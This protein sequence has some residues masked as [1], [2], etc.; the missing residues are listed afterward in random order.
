[1]ASRA[2][3][4]KCRHLPSYLF[5]HL[6]PGAKVPKDLMMP[7]LKRS[8]ETALFK[9]PDPKVYEDCLKEHVVSFDRDVRTINIQDRPNYDKASEYA[10]Q[11]IKKNGFDLAS[12][13]DVEFQVFI[14]SLH[15]QLM[16]EDPSSYRSTT[17]VISLSE[18][19]IADKILN[20]SN[21][22]LEYLSKNNLDISWYVYF[23]ENEKSLFKAEMGKIQSDDPIADSQVLCETTKAQ[24]QKYLAFTPRPSSIFEKMRAFFEEVRQR[25][26]GDQVEL[27]AFVHT[28]LLQI[29]PFQFANGRLA[30]LLM[31][32]VLWHHQTRQAPVYFYSY[33]E[34]TKAVRMGLKNPQV[35]ASYLAQK[36]KI[37]NRVYITSGH[38][39]LSKLR[40]SEWIEL[41]G[42]KTL[43]KVDLPDHKAQESGDSLQAQ[44]FDNS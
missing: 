37:F 28:G 3:A 27:A 30:R 5:P 19:G 29:H 35:F 24:L 6:H 16:G 25:A 10:Y 20:H 4:S 21:E 42:P 11:W 13:T 2:H 23:L 41:S 15:G 22:F 39:M 18:F 31:N 36:V 14:T 32:L 26:N 44:G 8:L 40:Q 1:M 9:T 34:Y 7:F 17:A 12:W 38:Q 43:L 33:Q